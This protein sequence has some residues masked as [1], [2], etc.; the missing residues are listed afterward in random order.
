MPKQQ[1]APGVGGC[2][3]AREHDGGT[4]GLC[5]GGQEEEEEE[6][7]VCRQIGAWL[8]E[9]EGLL[10]LLQSVSWALDRC[11]AAQP[12]LLLPMPLPAGG[13]GEAVRPGV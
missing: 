7:E 11:N 8:S 6:A 2:A 1:A 5:G 12:G 10:A 13:G 9:G 3:A 4:R